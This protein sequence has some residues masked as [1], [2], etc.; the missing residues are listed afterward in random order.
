MVQSRLPRVYL[1]RHGETEWS[2]S[3]QH[4]GKSDIPLTANGE[5]SVAKLVR[6]LGVHC[7]YMD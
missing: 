2:K 6:P 1:I 3:G 7:V 5:E 4:T